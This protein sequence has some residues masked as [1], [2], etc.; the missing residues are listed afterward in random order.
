M[1][2][3]PAV[4]AD[5]AEVL[6]LWSRARS[7]G[8]STPDDET[9]LR[10]LLERDPGA[11]LVAERDGELVGTLIAGWDGWRG[12]MYR[13]AVAPELRRQ[14]IAS[15]LIGEGERRLRAAGAR[16]VTA[17][18]WRDDDQAA[19]VWAATGYGDDA[20]VARFVRNLQRR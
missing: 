20:G 6:A 2:V 3:R 1:T 14:G 19:G 15:R 9:I 10:G 11:L 12:N 13:L 8:A 18:V 7:T 16:R 17:L 4:Q 5:L